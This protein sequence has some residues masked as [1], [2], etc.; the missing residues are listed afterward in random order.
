MRHSSYSLHCDTWHWGT[1]D[2]SGRLCTLCLKQ[3]QECEYYTL[4]YITICEWLWFQHIFDQ[5]QSL[6][7]LLSQSQWPL[8]IATYISKVPWILRVATHF[9]MNYVRMSYFLSHRSYLT[10]ADN[11]KIS[12]SISEGVHK[13]G[14]HIDPLTPIEEGKPIKRGFNCYVVSFQKAFWHCITHSAHVPA[15]IPWCP[16]RYAMGN[17]YALYESVEG[18]MWSPNGL[19]WLE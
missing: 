3:V 18:N 6:H 12:V 14:S 16:H 4:F 1:S 15:R 17:L 13:F 19:S 5:T 2:V 8:S 11:N 9:H 10:Y 7:E